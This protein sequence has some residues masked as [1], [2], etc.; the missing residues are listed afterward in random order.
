MTDKHTV[1]NESE[2]EDFWGDYLEDVQ[3][4]LRECKEKVAIDPNGQRDLGIFDRSF[5]Q[6]AAFGKGFGMSPFAF[7]LAIERNFSAARL[8]M[9][10]VTQ[11]VEPEKGVDDARS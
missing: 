4:V 6:I 10:K 3:K 7:L 9:L 1:T 8:A 2:A 5:D 11:V